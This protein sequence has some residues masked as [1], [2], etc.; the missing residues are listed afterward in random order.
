[1]YKAAYKINIS[2]WQN[3]YAGTPSVPPGERSIPSDSVQG[4]IVCTDENAA[5]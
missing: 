4:S 3:V 2:E 1:M 5:Q